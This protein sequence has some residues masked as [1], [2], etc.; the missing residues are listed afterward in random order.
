MATAAKPQEQDR[1]DKLVT[2]TLTITDDQGNTTT[3]EREIAEGPTPVPTL[4]EE[5]GVSAADSLFIVKHGK[6][7]MLAD[8]EKHNVKEGD[9]FEVVSK[10]GV[11]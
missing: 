11:S 2:V 5:L 7:K 4:K 1:H 6:P 10:G 3:I 8:H 9:H